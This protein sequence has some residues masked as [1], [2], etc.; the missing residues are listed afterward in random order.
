MEKGQKCPYGNKCPPQTP[1][2]GNSIRVLSAGLSQGGHINKL[3][4][5]FLSRLGMP[6]DHYSTMFDV[7]HGESDL[8]L[9]SELQM[10]T[11][12]LED[13]PELEGQVM[14]SAGSCA[15]S[16]QKPIVSQQQKP[17]SKTPGDPA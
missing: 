3:R 8:I 1:A 5:A 9:V 17:I 6:E 13:W 12:L 14:T 7:E 4:R 11:R 15:D 10:K 16:G 2:R